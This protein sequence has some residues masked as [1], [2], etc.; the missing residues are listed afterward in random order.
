VSAIFS[1]LCSFI[2]ILLKAASL[3]PV[4]TL[5]RLLMLSPRRRAG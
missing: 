5:V 2:N 3:V 1:E 4:L